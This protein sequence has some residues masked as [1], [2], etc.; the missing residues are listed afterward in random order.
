MRFDKDNLHVDLL[1]GRKISVPL[2]W[3]PR[4]RNAT[5][6]Q[7]KNWRLIGKGVGIHWTDLDEDSCIGALLR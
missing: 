1:D 2:E 3:F 7:K 5:L 4:L 6:R